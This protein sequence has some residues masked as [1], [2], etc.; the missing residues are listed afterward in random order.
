MV[1]SDTRPQSVYTTPRDYT[2]CFLFYFYVICKYYH[3]HEDG[4]VLDNT[5]SSQVLH[6]SKDGVVLGTPIHDSQREI[7]LRE[8]RMIF[9]L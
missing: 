6:T 1:Q 7:T 5:Y 4:G 3:T 9:P 8:S 2:S